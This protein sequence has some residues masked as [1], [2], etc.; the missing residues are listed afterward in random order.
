MHAQGR[1][2][3]AEESGYGAWAVVRGVFVYVE[4]RWSEWEIIHF[5]IN[6]LE[7]L[8]KERSNKV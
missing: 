4:G 1:L 7:T 2:Y 8:I 5:S 3:G 6:V